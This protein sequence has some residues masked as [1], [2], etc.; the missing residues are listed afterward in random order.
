MKYIIIAFLFVNLSFSQKVKIKNDKII[1][2][3]KEVFICKKEDFNGDSLT[4]H[5]L[6]TNEE[7]IFIKENNGG[8]RGADSRHDD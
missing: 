4:I 7:L 1:I 8:T 3:D 2:D 5:D 6:K